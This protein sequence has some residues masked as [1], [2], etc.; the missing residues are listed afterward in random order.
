MKAVVA[1]R[2]KGH[3][4]KSALGTAQFERVGDTPLL[5]FERL[6]HDLH[7]KVVAPLDGVRPSALRGA[8]LAIVLGAR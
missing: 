8:Q 1:A 6:A 4:H 3:G 7:V 5:R 2:T